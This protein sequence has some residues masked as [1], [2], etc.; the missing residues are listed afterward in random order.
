MLRSLAFA[1]WLYGMTTVLG[2]AAIP[3]R[4]MARGRILAY[5]QGWA[6]LVLGGLR[7]LCGV[8]LV[9]IGGEHLPRGG[10][11][12]IA[13]EHESAFDTLVWMTLLPRPAYVLKRELT[14]IPLFG[15]LLLGA[16]MI[17]VRRED[18]AA[19]LRRLL[20][21]TGRAVA[22]GRQV[23]IFPQGTRVAPGASTAPLQPGI[24]AVARASGLPV[25]PVATDSGRRWPRRG[26]RKQAGPIHI[27]LR[28]A[29][30]PGLSRRALLA[31]LETE[32]AAGRA[33]I[34]D[35]ACGR[36]AVDRTGE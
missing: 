30:Q 26:F 32:W 19:A 5:A 22:D 3:L 4:L 20:A 13:S 33:A 14:R 2:V 28:P 18:G 12:L 6:G 8:R 11:A 10:P 16:G 36:P 9:V 21:D 35:Q 1:A 15:P 25:I 17:A 29:I 7:R 27:V 23:V 31:R 34:A 24:V